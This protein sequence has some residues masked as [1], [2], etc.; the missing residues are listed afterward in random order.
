MTCTPHAEKIV[1]PHPLR[2]TAEIP[3]PLLAV[4][5][6]EAIIEELESVDDP[7]YEEA[8]LTATDFI[9]SQVRSA[10]WY[11]EKARG[12]D[13]FER[14]EVTA[15]VPLSALTEKQV[16]DCFGFTIVASECIDSVGIDHWIGFANGHSGLLLPSEEGQGLH[17]VDPLS[18]VL[19]QDLQ[20]SLVSGSTVVEDMSR[21]GRSAVELNT[22][23]LAH[24]ARGDDFDLLKEHP[25]LIFKRSED[26]VTRE[27]EYPDD[28]GSHR[29][30]DSLRPARLKVLMSVY[31]PAD[32]RQM[33]QE[34]NAFQLAYNQGDFVGAAARV[35]GMRGSFPQVDA[36]RNHTEIKKI[37]S[38]LGKHDMV[39]YARRVMDSYFES[40]VLM[41][42]DSRF[43][44]AEGDALRVLAR[45]GQD[46][47]SA[48]QA[49]MR[50]EATLDPNKYPHAYKETAKAKLAKAVK[51]CIG[52]ETAAVNGDLDTSA[53]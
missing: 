11:P 48:Q 1:A 51:L 24:R 34:Y 21:Y 7:M 47:E 41:D 16:A 12:R 45:E 14:F 15:P 52:L 29:E 49:I 4:I 33:L 25:W 40:F 5:E 6:P 38:E 43:K 10:L 2:Q 13:D 20:H 39:A 9:C 42:G 46:L 50:Y 19:S 18:P 27:F 32:G 35:Q 53:G 28:Y 22:F 31:K 36:R 17:F 3:Q 26:T 8:A 44:M 37:V 23:S 30:P